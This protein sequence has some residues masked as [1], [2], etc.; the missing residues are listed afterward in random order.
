[1]YALMIDFA[2]RQHKKQEVNMVKLIMTAKAM[3]DDEQ[4]WLELRN[5]YIGGSD[6]AVVAGISKW[7]SPY[8]LWREKT[9]QAEPEDLS[10]NMRVWF[11]KEN[12]NTVAKR[13]TLDTGK[14]VKRTGVYINDK[15]PWACASIDRMIVGEKSFLE[16]K[17]SS[18]FTK[19][20]WENDELPDNYYLQILHYMTVL[21]MDYCYIACMINNCSDY[22]IRK[23]PFNKAEAAALMQL[24]EQFYFDYIIGG[25]EP[26]MD[27][28]EA[29]SKV[30]SDKYIGGQIEPVEMPLEFIDKAQRLSVI[31]GKIKE[32]QTEK[33]TI[34]NEAKNFLGNDEHGYCGNYHFDWTTSKCRATIDSKKLK[35]EYPA[36]YDKCV[37]VAKPTRRFTFK[38]VGA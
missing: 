11:G 23:V 14:E 18:S 25:K 8:Q 37:K 6:A 22:F 38:E 2:T 15:Y 27:G 1:M 12:E 3:Q 34:E 10:N 13:F 26:P 30:L 29:T 21:E 7:K 19:S 28:S 5:K 4:A 36:I 24:E 35:A 20:Q 31:N 33:S 17:T 9:H 32:L 16:C